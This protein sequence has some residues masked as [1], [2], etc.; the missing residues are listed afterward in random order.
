[1][2]TEL[3]IGALL[4]QSY[5]EVAKIIN[6]RIEQL[7]YTEIRSTHFPVLQPLFFHPTGMTSSE[8]ANLAGITKQSMG[9]MVKYL[10]EYGYVERTKSPSDARA[11]LIVL[12][13]KGVELMNRIYGVVSQLD[14]HFAEQFGRERFQ[15]LRSLL[16]D[17]LPVL[18][19]M[20]QK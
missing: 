19:N 16:L 15:D 11:W 1:L 6:Q 13:P 3:R 7:E 18:Q 2:I 8:L 12:T 9:E 17:F 14:E 10:E 4:R 20:N 5:Q